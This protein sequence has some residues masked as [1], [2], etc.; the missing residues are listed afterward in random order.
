M[1]WKPEN[2]SA[3]MVVTDVRIRREVPL[4][5]MDVREVRDLRKKTRM[6]V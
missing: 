1:N 2:M 6:A 3:P 4:L 5:R